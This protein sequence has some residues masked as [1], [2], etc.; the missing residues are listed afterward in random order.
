MQQQQQH[1]QRKYD[2]YILKQAGRLTA[3]FIL[4]YESDRRTDRAADRASEHKRSTSVFALAR[5]TYRSIHRVDWDWLVYRV[6]NSPARCFRK[7][8]NE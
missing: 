5:P 1:Q 8:L 4:R 2:E 6:E 3:V 7:L